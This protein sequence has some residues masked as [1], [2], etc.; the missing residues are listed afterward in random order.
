MEEGFTTFAVGAGKSK[1]IMADPAVASNPNAIR[2]CAIA[3]R[4]GFSVKAAIEG[5]IPNPLPHRS[6]KTLLKK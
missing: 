1:E 3:N 5:P 4:D 6:F 2:L